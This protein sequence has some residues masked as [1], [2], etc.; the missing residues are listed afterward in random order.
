VIV[1][2]H[3]PEKSEA[4]TAEAAKVEASEEREKA[5]VWHR[6]TWRSSWHITLY[7]APRRS[8]RKQCGTLQDN[9]NNAEQ[10]RTM[11]ETSRVRHHI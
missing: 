5:M 2:A 9:Q 7:D 3:V 11:T 10:C 6:H 4:S 8:K 1:P